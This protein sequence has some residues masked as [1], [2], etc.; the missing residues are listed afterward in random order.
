[1]IYDLRSFDHHKVDRYLPSVAWLTSVVL[2]EELSELLLYDKIVHA[3]GF[4]Q[5]ML[6]V[7]NQLLSLRTDLH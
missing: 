2:N 3:S 6:L 4:F 7:N 5:A 1:M